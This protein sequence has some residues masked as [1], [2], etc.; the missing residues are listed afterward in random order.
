[1][2]EGESQSIF[3]LRFDFI[4]FH[5]IHSTHVTVLRRRCQ[6]PTPRTTTRSRLSI[7]DWLVGPGAR[8]F[9]S[10]WFADSGHTSFDQIVFGKQRHGRFYLWW[11]RRKDVRTELNVEH[12]SKYSFL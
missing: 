12:S 8:Y 3:D 11:L 2:N 4:S 10:D 6:I 1:M 9:S 5:L 7:F